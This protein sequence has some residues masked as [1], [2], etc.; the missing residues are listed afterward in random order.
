MT[1]V[2][3]CALPISP[4]S[5]QT[6]PS[7]LTATLGF[8]WFSSHDSTSVLATGSLVHWENAMDKSKNGRI[9]HLFIIRSS[10]INSESYLNRNPFTNSLIVK[11]NKITATNI[12]LHA[13]ALTRH[14]HRHGF[15]VLSIRNISWHPWT[16]RSCPY[17]IRPGIFLDNISL[18][19]CQPV[20]LLITLLKLDLST[21]DG[22]NNLCFQN[23]IL[24]HCHNVFWKYGNISQFT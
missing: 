9:V 1:G 6:E 8:N 21:D 22:I 23:L 5:T 13:G 18:L 17:Q 3:T 12:V 14:H 16:K 7:E 2:Q 10:W 15:Q 19:I 11:L 24:G 20:H 4:H